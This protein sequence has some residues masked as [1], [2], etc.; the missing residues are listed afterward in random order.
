MLVIRRKAGES[1][2]IGDDIEI[3]VIDIS[4]TRV[5]LGIKAPDT[6]AILRKEIRLT[7]EQNRQAA[8]GVSAAAIEDFVARLRC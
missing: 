8:R 4:P 7:G 3:E 5:K 1:V 6:I 2:L